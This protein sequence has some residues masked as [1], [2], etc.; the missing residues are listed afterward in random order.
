MPDEHYIDGYRVLRRLTVAE[1]EAEHMVVR[2]WLWWRTRTPFGYINDQ[3]RT[4][5]SHMVDGD[6][7]WFTSSPQ[8]EWDRLM[9][10]SG[11]LL[12]RNGKVVDSLL[13][14]LN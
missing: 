12:V 2:G 6:E 10:N 3:W 4:L 7:L 1:A 8:E 13:L 11:I 9:G 14:S 5:V